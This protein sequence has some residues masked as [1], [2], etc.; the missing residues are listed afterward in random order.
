[1]IFSTV[2]DGV[3]FMIRQIGVSDVTHYLDDLKKKK[4]S[5][6][7]CTQPWGCVVTWGTDICKWAEEVSLLLLGD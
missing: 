3:E 1:M 4:N 2:A 7:P 6:G 5:V